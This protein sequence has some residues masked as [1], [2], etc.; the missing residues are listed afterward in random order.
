MRAAGLKAIATVIDSTAILIKSRNTTNNKLVDL[1]SARIRGVISESASAGLERPADSNF[2][3]TKIHSLHIQY[4][5]VAAVPGNQDYP[6]EKS[7]N[8]NRT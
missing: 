3:C 6:G 1:I 7:T 8:H 5:S 4:Q 2:S